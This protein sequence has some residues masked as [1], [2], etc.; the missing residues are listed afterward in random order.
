MTDQPETTELTSQAIRE[1]I[2]KAQ[3]ELDTLS[4]VI[5]D[6]QAE[7]RKLAAL[8][9]VG[10]LTG[11]KVDRQREVVDELAT[12]QARKTDLA[13]GIEGAQEFLH[14][15]LETERI[16]KARADWN[17]AEAL[18]A[19]AQLVAVGAQKALEEAGALFA[20]LES[21][22][23]EAASL[24]KPHMQPVS[25]RSTLDPERLKLTDVVGL[26]LKTAGGPTFPFDMPYGYR[27]GDVP[28]IKSKV[29]GHARQF[30]DWRER[31]DWNERQGD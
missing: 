9:T 8:A 10:L 7:Q 16:A 18:L 29:A 22:L 20:K 17:E 5:A 30:A 31:Q 6:L 12:L 11:P 15:A 26:I 4:P 14:R 28:S 24:A 25:S 13:A 3:H 23:E 21:L 19:E 27:P 1:G 2:A